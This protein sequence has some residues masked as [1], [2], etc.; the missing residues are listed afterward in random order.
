[1]TKL[2]DLIVKSAERG[3]K[4]QLDNGSMPAGHNGPYNDLETPVRNT[5]HWCV[6]FLKVFEWT[7]KRKFRESAEKAANYLV[8]KE[9]RPMNATFWCRK[10]PKRDFSNGLIGQAWVMEALALASNK[11]NIPIYGAIAEEVFLLHP[12]DKKTGLWQGVNV[13]GSY[14]P[15]NV[16]FNQQ[17]W[18]ATSGFLL[19]KY[20]EVRDEVFYRVRRFFE[21]LEKNLD[22]HKNGLI[23]HIIH[24]PFY[25][26]DS[27]AKLVYY[28]IKKIRRR[29]SQSYKELEIGYHSF[30]LYAL[31]LLKKENGLINYSFW[32]SPKLRRALQYA[33]TQ[34]YRDQLVENK[35]AFSY[36]PVGFE[37]SFALDAFSDLISNSNFTL[38]GCIQDQIEK[39]Y[40]FK[41]GLM[42]KN[43]T[44][45]NTLAARIYEATRLPNLEI[46]I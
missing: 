30:N 17:L 16:V 32:K 43:T 25:S 34:K 2:W 8:S 4:M 10:N 22:V 6:T 39:H 45:P 26:E 20:A 5:A 28:N 15:L 24:K 12:F 11:L 27:I 29:H 41:E 42:C 40:S 3:I 44:D 1:M 14:L 21:Q 18:F 38:L 23:S 9:A 35:Y 31:A 19:T 33:T 7:G 13:D 36:N 46:D 37:I